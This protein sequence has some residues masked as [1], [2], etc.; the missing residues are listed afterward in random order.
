MTPI[1]EKHCNTECR[2]DILTKINEC[3]RVSGVWKFTGITVTVIALVWAA[4]FSIHAA[5]SERVEERQEAAERQIAINTVSI[6][7]ILQTLDS[8]EKSQIRLEGKL[9]TFGA[10]IIKEVKKQR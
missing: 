9:D 5:G 10:A 1:I 7:R 3:I 2:E 8:L 6:A 4:A